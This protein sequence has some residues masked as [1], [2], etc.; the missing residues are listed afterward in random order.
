MTGWVWN[1]GGM[2]LTEGKKPVLN[3]VILSKTNPAWIGLE[4]NLGCGG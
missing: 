2:K 1:S 4:S 3:T